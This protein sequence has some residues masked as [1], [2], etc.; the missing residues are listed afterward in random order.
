MTICKFYQSGNCKFGDQC[1][2]EHIDANG[3]GGASGPDPFA[4]AP[5]SSRRPP[6]RGGGNTHARPTRDTPQWPLT[7]VGAHPLSSGNTVTGDM[8]QEELRVR[9]YA[10]APQQRGC[11]EEVVRSEQAIVAEHQQRNNGPS[12]PSAQQS[13][14]PPDPF[15]GSAGPSSGAT[16]QPIFG[17]V[18][19]A[20]PASNTPIFPTS[21]PQAVPGVGFNNQ[22]GDGFAQ[23]FPQQ[24]PQMATPPMATPPQQQPNPANGSEGFTQPAFAFQQVPGRLCLLL[25]A[26]LSLSSILSLPQ[27]TCLTVFFSHFVYVLPRRDCAKFSVDFAF[28]RA[29]SHRS[30]FPPRRGRRKCVKSRNEQIKAGSA[31]WLAEFRRDDCLV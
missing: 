30:P 9:A 10:A 12:A 28:I 26:L 23:A 7:S 6:G 15:A 14:A 2:F 29:T 27:L 5:R 18:S 31:A 17:G 13:H 11:T 20:A 22:P 25:R 24:S 19:A 4:P 1:K 21:N 16:Q 3:H 8:S